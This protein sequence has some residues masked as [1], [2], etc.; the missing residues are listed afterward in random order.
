MRRLK[1]V[2]VVPP[3][4][5]YLSV[6]VL[7]PAVSP[8]RMA[9]PGMAK[10]NPAAGGDACPLFPSAAATVVA[11]ETATDTKAV[12]PPPPD[13]AAPATNHTRTD[14]PVVR[15]TDGPTVARSV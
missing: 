13:L 5:L 2:T 9:I 8:V 6:K 10:L 12:F 11:P 1:K 3:S 15:V 4:S 7:E 14:V